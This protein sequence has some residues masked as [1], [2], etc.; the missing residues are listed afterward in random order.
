M[1]LLECLVCGGEVEIINEDH[2]VN[3][4]IKCLNCGFNN[5]DD[6]FAKK[7]EIVIM[8]RRTPSE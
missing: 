8:K 1:K 5:I 2:A 7:P 4:K 3:K 6:S